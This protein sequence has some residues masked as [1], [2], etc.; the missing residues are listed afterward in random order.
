MFMISKLNKIKYLL[1]IVICNKCNLSMWIVIG[2]TK[3]ML[4][5]IRA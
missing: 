3:L 2:H 5:V 4:P 1:H